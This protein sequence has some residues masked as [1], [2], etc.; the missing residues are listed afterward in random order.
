[1]GYTYRL[2]KTNE[3][4]KTRRASY[5]E[6]LLSK[7]T[8]FQL[9]EICR[10]EKL[11]M[12]S[13]NRLDREELIRLV[14]KYRGE[15]E[16]LLITKHDEE[17]F[18]RLQEFIQKT[19][20]IAKSDQAIDAPA[21]IEIYQG[22]DLDLFDGYKA[23][24]KGGLD[25]GNLLL[26]DG[27]FKIR[28]IFNIV[29]SNGSSFIVKDKE[30]YADKSG[31][32]NFRLLYFARDY[33]DIIYEMYTSGMECPPKYI[34]FSEIPIMDFC[35]KE[36]EESSR[37]LAIDFG[38]SNT[39]AGAYIGDEVNTVMV[40]NSL[41]EECAHTPLI[42]SVIGVKLID[43]EEIEYKF[44]YDAIKLS[45]SS[46][47][48][49]G[50]CIFYDIKRW[51]ADYEREENAVDIKGNRRPIKRKD[52]IKAYL[53]Y[54]IGMSK[55]RFK[56]NFKK[57]HISCPT[58]QK[59]RFYA[60][61][62]E[63]LSEYE[64]EYADMLDEG[65]AVLFNTISGMISQKSYNDGRMH[66]ALIIDCGGG[67]TD[68]SSCE[69]SITSDRVS[70]GIAM[71]TSY[72]N[73]DTDFGGNNLTY[74]IMQMI[75]LV[76][77]ESLEASAF[78]A[79]RRIFE[80]MD[81]DLFRSVDQ[82]GISA[83]YAEID[84]LYEKAE[85]LI[86]TRFADYENKSG[87]DYF[88]VKSNYYALFQLAEEV[89]KDFFSD[90]IKTHIEITPSEEVQGGPHV[91]YDRWRIYIKRTGGF[92]PMKDSVKASINVYEVETLLK[93]EIYAVIKKFLEPLDMEGKLEEYKIIKLTGQSCRIDI[94]KEAIK[95]FIPGRKIMSKKTKK[96]GK[97]EYDLKLVCL[98]GALE[99]LRLKGLGYIDLDM[100]SKIP[101]LP[102]LISAY[103]HTG[104]EKTLIRS[105]D[106][107]DSSASISRAMDRIELKLQL[108]DSYGSTKHEYVYANRPED[109][110]KT[111]FDAIAKRYPG[112][113]SQDQT[114]NIVNGEVKFFVWAQK[115][116]WGFCVLPV[117][118]SGDE[119]SLGREEFFNFENDTWETNF[120][121]G[122]K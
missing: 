17:G 36:L 86:P 21:K 99:Y 16:S 20:K 118:R 87:E 69:F 97:D 25:E 8:T 39:T 46:Y 66:K 96:D 2:Y 85:T 35:V 93:S 74:R 19:E 29:N 12:N 56:M 120:F 107:H 105:L 95:E 84:N 71:S 60:L 77:A 22:V 47:I 90:R 58:K 117:S 62:R 48:D 114:D 50:I 40:E 34:R 45:K 53:E 44:G 79:R 108:K 100:A 110:V 30:I 104:S 51:I 28:T 81:I 101:S 43:G 27:E 103:S 98:K 76:F 83:I 75:K 70:Y 14:M 24:A 65:G 63:I 73:G 10:R 116:D 18:L 106:K 88:K 109:F 52:M 11:V 92:E 38:T 82:G 4:E 115:E 33:S 37:H 111:T 55:Q 89:K 72:E 42:P 32:K 80:E 54:V 59:R 112:R 1:M 102:Y 9:R 3:K 13:I 5:R 119:L 68:L 41:S 94:F 78:D 23:V 121:D 57:I 31:G 7:M 91:A 61:F 67:T 15:R 64:I 113:I 26:V 49:D 122:N 6:N